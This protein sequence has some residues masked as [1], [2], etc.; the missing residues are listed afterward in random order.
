MVFSCHWELL[1]RV[2]VIDAI[3]HV[4]SEEKGPNNW[5]CCSWELTVKWSVGTCVELELVKSVH[6]TKLSGF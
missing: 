1:E 4:L 2:Q 6:I 5:L 3:A